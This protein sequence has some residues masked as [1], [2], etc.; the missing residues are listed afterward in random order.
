[1]HERHMMHVNGSMHHI[2]LWI[3]IRFPIKVSIFL[4]FVCNY[5]NWEPSQK[6]TNQTQRTRTVELIDVKLL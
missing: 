6:T 1:M 5:S 2:L 4:D 3:Y